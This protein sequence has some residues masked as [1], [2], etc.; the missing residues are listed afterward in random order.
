MRGCGVKMVKIV[1]VLSRRSLGPFSCLFKQGTVHCTA[2]GTTS[3][4]LQQKT[5]LSC[6][7]LL[8]TRMRAAGRQRLVAF[9]ACLHVGWRI[10]V[11]TR[12]GRRAVAAWPQQALCP[13][14]IRLV[15]SS[16]IYTKYA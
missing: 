7:L 5:S 16:A 10:V 15:T 6:A 9:G 3:S 1:E 13:C 12:K 11:S 14:I 4:P 2:A 8:L